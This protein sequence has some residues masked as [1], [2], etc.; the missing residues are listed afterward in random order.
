MASYV[1]ATV[2]WTT[3]DCKKTCDVAFNPSE[4]VPKLKEQIQEATGIPKERVV[5]ISK[6]KGL[7]KGILKDD[8]D[9]FSIDYT[10]A[11]STSKNGR[12]QIMLTQN[13]VW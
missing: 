1:F 12:L 13:S 4:G 11:L 9:L 7:W 6:T 8:F 3:I 5:L 2:K 10:S